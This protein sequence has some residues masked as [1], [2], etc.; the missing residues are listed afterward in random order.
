MSIISLM[1][2]GILIALSPLPNKVIDSNNSGLISFGEAFDA[3]DVGTRVNPDNSRCTEY[4][5]F[6]DGLTAYE[7]CIN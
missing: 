2:Y 1:I 4:Y 3:V 7:K 5:W 6:K